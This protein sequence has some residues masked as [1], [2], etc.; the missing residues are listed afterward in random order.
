[1]ICLN[2]I[3]KDEAPVI[4]RCLASVK[5]HIDHWVIVDTGST[6]GTQDII[7]KEMA[8]IPGELHERPWQDF[9]T[10][11]NEALA[12][13][14]DKADY[15]L[16]IDADE[17]LLAEDWKWPALTEDGYFLSVNYDGLV[18][19][20]MA[21]V[22]TRLNWKW[23]GVLH[24]YIHADGAVR[25]HLPG[26]TIFVRHDGARGRN[27]ETYLKDIAVLEQAVKDDPDNPRNVYYL[28]QSYRDGGRLPEALKW[29]DHRSRMKGWD[30]E[31]WHAAYQ[32]ARVA[33][34]AKAPEGD[35]MGRYLSA[36]MLRPSRAE[37]LYHLAQFHR[38]RGEWPLAAMYARQAARIPV[39]QDLLFLE[40]PIYRWG[41]KDELATACFATGEHSE[42]REVIKD[43]L[44]NGDPPAEDRQRLQRNLARIAEYSI[45]VVNNHPVFA[46][47]AESL[48]HA[49]D[50]L[51][52]VALLVDKPEEA[53]GRQIW[54]GANMLPEMPADAII[55][56]LEQAGG[57]WMRE[58]YLKLL[59]THEVWDYSPKNVARLKELGV[60]AKLMK[61]GYTPVMEKIEP[62]E[63]DIDVL[64]VGSIDGTKRPPLLDA[65]GKT[66]LNCKFVQGVYGEERDKLYARS[67]I[68]LN[69]HAYDDANFETVRVSYLLANQRFVLSE[70]ADDDSDFS[71]AVAFGD[72]EELPK[73]CKEYV[74]ASKE[75][76]KIAR[77][78]YER[79]KAM[80]QERFL[81]QVL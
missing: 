26:P 36:Y 17:T 60:E 38:T 11:R 34:V 41:A 58:E 23:T 39:P 8:D 79:I 20:R 43:I 7:R 3:V 54:L 49:F 27:P 14:K 50:A 42:A 67:K 46:E 47:V 64:F 51:G 13:A 45:V 76:K 18:Y 69:T 28:A 5:P 55:F 81:S 73:L 59:R 21:I 10:N 2:M 16:F 77:R 72:A 31:T 62:A 63:E 25:K 4:A 37:S 74:R 53:V 78:G 1:M 52:K 32:A 70:Y 65:I 30:E 22:A 35:V 71:G 15:V 48:L 75:R 61:I 9:A 44:A 66:G 19:A 68:V 40:G 12:L 57:W 6:D 80:P 29:Y 33:H 56:N 24:E